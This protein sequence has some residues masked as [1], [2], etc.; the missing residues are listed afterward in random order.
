MTC[1]INM[2]SNIREKYGLLL[3]LI[4]ETTCASGSGMSRTK[5]INNFILIHISEFIQDAICV[6][7][8]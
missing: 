8:F 7:P 5:H 6:F 3:K 4:S 2:P 1:Y